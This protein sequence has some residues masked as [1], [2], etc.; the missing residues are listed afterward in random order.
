MELRNIIAARLH[1]L[2]RWSC[3]WDSET[4]PSVRYRGA[5]AELVAASWLRAHGVKI[6]RRNF[7]AGHSGEIDLVCRQGDTLVFAEVKS[8]IHPEHGA[9]SRA[10]NR[11]KRHLLRRGA[12]NWLYMLGF[13]VPIRFD[14]LEI[15]LNTKAPPSVTWRQAAFSLHEGSAR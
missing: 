14:I 4:P 2:H 15:F 10:V 11:R 9:P 12:R 3:P 13:P 8:T 5:Y 6:L 7:R 1:L